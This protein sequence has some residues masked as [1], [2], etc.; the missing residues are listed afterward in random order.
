[1]PLGYGPACKAKVS[2]LDENIAALCFCLNSSKS[3]DLKPMHSAQAQ[4]VRV[5]KKYILVLLVT[6]VATLQEVRINVYLSLIP[7]QVLMF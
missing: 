6:T 4:S 7:S 1:M 2:R 5:M 3:D